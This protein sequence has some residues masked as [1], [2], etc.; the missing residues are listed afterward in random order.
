VFLC[1][2]C[3]YNLKSNTKTTVKTL[4]YVLYFFLW[5]EYILSPQ[6]GGD[7]TALQNNTRTKVIN[8]SQVFVFFLRLAVFYCPQSGGDATALHTRRFYGVRGQ[9]PRFVT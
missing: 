6:S 5:L 4:S 7:A 1:V 2:L 3:G 9:R 8:L